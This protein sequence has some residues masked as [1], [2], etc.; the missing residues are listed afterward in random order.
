MQTRR[1][2]TLLATSYDVGAVLTFEGG[3]GV[4][5]VW[6]EGQLLLGQEEDLKFVAVNLQTQ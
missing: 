3:V 2:S 5:V 6:K 4:E 1:S